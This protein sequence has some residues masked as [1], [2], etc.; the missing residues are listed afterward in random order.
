MS[1]LRL[2]LCSGSS[3]RLQQVDSTVKGPLNDYHSATIPNQLTGP[4]FLDT[5]ESSPLANV[6]TIM[7][8][9]TIA[10]GK[11]VAGNA[12][13]GSENTMQLSWRA[14]LEKKITSFLEEF[15]L[16]NFKQHTASLCT[17]ASGHLPG[18]PTYARASSLE[19]L[20]DPPLA[21]QARSE[22]PQPSKL[23]NVK[24]PFYEGKKPEGAWWLYQKCQ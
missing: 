4:Q 10:L 7:K 24:P 12:Q 1:V 9:F 5:G 15:T 23:H 14:E 20:A 18:K 13:A 2:N 8:P 19:A 16:Q 21:K 11:P 17:E 22:E 6:R 3:G